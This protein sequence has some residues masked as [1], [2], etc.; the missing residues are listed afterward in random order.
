MKAVNDQNRHNCTCSECRWWQPHVSARDPKS[1]GYKM[2]TCHRYAPRSGAEE[3]FPVMGEQGFCGEWEH[4]IDS[5]EE[6]TC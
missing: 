6:A 2:E 4:V 3:I 5:E 1:G